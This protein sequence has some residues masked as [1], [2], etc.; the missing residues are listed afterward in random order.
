MEPFLVEIKNKVV[1]LSGLSDLEANFSLISKRRKIL[2]FQECK[3]NSGGQYRSNNRTNNP[4]RS[5]QKHP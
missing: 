3:E 2:R 1:N 4:I 5:G